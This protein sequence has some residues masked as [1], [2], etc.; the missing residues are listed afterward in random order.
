MKQEDPKY[1]SIRSKLRNLDRRRISLRLW[2]RR[3]SFLVLG[4]R[5]DETRRSQIRK[6]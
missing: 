1:E 4:G 2:L 3:L 6:Y 5:R